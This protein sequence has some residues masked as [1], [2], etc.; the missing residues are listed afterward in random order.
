MPLNSSGPIS[1]AGSTTGQSI[2]LELGQSATGQIS[3]NDSN[4]RS[5]A[6]VASGAI[7]MP[8]NFWGKS[9]AFV[10]N[11]TISSDT[12]YYN[13]LSAMQAA[14]YTNGSSYQA[15]VTIN[16]GIYVWS[17]DVSLP[18]FDT[19]AITGTGTINIINNGY[20][21]GKGGTCPGFTT[22]FAGT[23]TFNQAGGPAMVIQKPV[24]I[25]NNAYIAGGGGSGGTAA[26]LF[27]TANSQ[28][29]GAGGGAGGGGGGPSC[30]ASGTFLYVNGG[31]GGAPGQ[32]GTAGSSGSANAGGG[33]GGRILPGSGGA[34]GSL[35]VGTAGSGGGGGS[36]GGNSSNLGRAVAAFSVGQGGGAGGGGGIGCASGKPGGDTSAGGGGGGWGAVGGT[37][38]NYNSSIATTVYLGVGGA[39]GNAIS[40]GG[41]AVTWATLGTVYGAVG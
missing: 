28:R 4:V 1:L 19:G 40:T 34:G 12:Q 15:T 38:G 16:S 30:Y 8:T 11:A 14:G 24:T 26:L 37:G 6:G 27:L 17:D 21:I 7:T 32:S 9:N 41:N 5:L 18:A 25:T 39:G 20:I 13:L 23:R 2:A 10:F 22:Y 33:G 3:L 36:A 35:S 31:S 29:G